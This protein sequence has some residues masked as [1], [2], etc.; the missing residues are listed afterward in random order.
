MNFESTQIVFQRCM[1]DYYFL[2]KNLFLYRDRMHRLHLIRKSHELTLPLIN[3]YL[4][5]SLLCERLI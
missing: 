1:S 4:L 3:F 5:L 2:N